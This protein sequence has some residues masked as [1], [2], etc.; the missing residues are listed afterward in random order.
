VKEKIKNNKKV[1][2]EWVNLYS[3][4]LYSWALHKTSNKEVAE[5]LVQETFLAAFKSVNNFNNDSQPGTWLFSILNNKIIDYY[6]K[7]A[8]SIEKPKENE[9]L[10]EKATD[11][12]FN[13]KGQWENA[14]SSN[15]QDEEHLL[16]NKEFTIILS[17]CI[18]K[19]PDNWRIAIESKYQKDKKASE[20]CKELNIT[21][22]NYWQ[23]IHRA[24]LQL[25][26]CIEKNWNN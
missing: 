22:S 16:D 18:G 13:A 4:K 20:I 15:W 5:D 1:V 21:S 12:L 8:K 2:T 25:K 26:I 17:L 24:K 23:M 6:R 14:H 11:S 10:S 3:D 7:S 19:L 9:L